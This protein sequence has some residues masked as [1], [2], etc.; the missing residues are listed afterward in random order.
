M[1]QSEVVKSLHGSVTNFEA[2]N[3]SVALDEL[4][5][6][7]ILQPL[8][9]FFFFFPQLEGTWKWKKLETAEI[10]GHIVN[11]RKITWNDLEYKYSGM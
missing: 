8:K 1:G 3:T 10:S 9:F 5:K 7:S 6:Q 2:K 4:E 11:A